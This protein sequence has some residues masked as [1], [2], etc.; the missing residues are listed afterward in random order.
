[1]DDSERDTIAAKIKTAMHKHKEET[2][3]KTARKPQAKSI[4][5][6]ANLHCAKG[7]DKMLV[8]NLNA[9]LAKFMYS[10]VRSFFLSFLFERAHA[11]PSIRPHLKSKHQTLKKM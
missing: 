8:W 2:K 10:D 7:L 5:M 4:P 1:M 6:L 11:H 3:K 9:G